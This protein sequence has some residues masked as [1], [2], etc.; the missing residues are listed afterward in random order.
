MEMF[1]NFFS[2]EATVFFS[3]EVAAWVAVQ[4][5]G[6]QDRRAQGRGQCTVSAARRAMDVADARGWWHAWG[7][8]SRRRRR[9]TQ[10]GQG[11][12]WG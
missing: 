5:S 9:T 12:S 1:N 3:S 10:Q 7:A 6:A 2:G 11:C 4:A 8:Q